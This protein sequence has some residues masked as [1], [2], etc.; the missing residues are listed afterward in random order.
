[1]RMRMPFCLEVMNMSGGNRGY[2]TN[3]EKLLWG[4][5]A[6]AI[7]ASFL[8]FD[9]ASWLT[10]IASLTGVT[11]LI[12]SAKGHPLGQVL[13]V[14]FSLMYGVISWL[15]RYY[16][17]MITY[18]G[19]TMPMAV[20]ALIAWLRHPFGDNRQEVAVNRI[21]RGE[22]LLCCLLTAAVT[23]AFYFI[24]KAFH[25]SHLSLST[26]SVTTSFLA[27]YLTYRRSPLFAA[28]YAANDVVL[29]LLW[30]LAAAQDRSCISVV[31]CFAAFL[32]NDLYGFISWR[33]MAQR[34]AA[35]Q[36][37]CVVWPKRS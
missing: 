25:T 27:V 32:A 17:E 30:C 2:F 14:L 35:A 34:Q 4:V 8:L 3:G 15:A 5:S 28:A 36:A 9:R 18:L 6:A 1:M 19:M 12:Y 26:L 29:I 37:D 13:M 11:S 31:V 20:F 21:S 10:L 33:R 24:L 22:G 7:V 23:A 16:G